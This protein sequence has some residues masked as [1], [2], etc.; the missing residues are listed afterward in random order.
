MLDIFDF[1]RDKQTLDLKD[2]KLIIE[3]DKLQKSYLECTQNPQRCTQEQPIVLQQYKTM[4][5]FF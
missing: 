2:Q 3:T 5:F 4:F 1:E